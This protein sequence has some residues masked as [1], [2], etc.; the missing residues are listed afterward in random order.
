[1]K[2][3]QQ[4]PL[5]KLRDALTSH[6]SSPAPLSISGLLLAW[7]DVHRRKLPWR[8]DNADAY[9]VWLSEIMLQQTTVKAVIPF[10]EK[11]IALWP[12]VRA[13]ACAPTAEVMSAWAGLGYYSRARN[14]HAC[15]KLVADTYQGSF[16]A[17]E[18]DLRK[19][20]GIGPYTA[21]AISA[22]A[23]DRRAVVVD[24][25][26]ER[27]VSRLFAVQTPLPAAKPQIYTLTDSITPERRCGDFAQSMMDL[28]ASLCAPRAPQCLIC[29]LRALCLAHRS[30]DP[31]TFPRK[32]PKPE[33]PLRRG[34]VFHITRADGA[35]LARTRPG[36]GLLG[37]MTELPTTAWN[38]DFQ[39][40]TAG[41]FAPLI[42]PYKAASSVHHVFTHFALEL[43]VF[44]A[45]VDTETSAPPPYRWVPRE[46]MENEAWPSVMRKVLK[47]GAA[48]ER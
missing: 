27:V 12:D 33:R 24:G 38:V 30:G 18:A 45:T 19:L 32:S 23:F 5:Q 6:R 10:F 47:S 11:F 9:S 36:K 16:P 17:D 4:V 1:M 15:A 39:S 13:L 37:G 41:D 25:N 35:L 2:P 29:P 26:V 7:Y 44:T 14:L 46:K 34:A 40:P 28:G 48:Y 20:P 3:L 21:A 42:A 31:Q 43:L 22:I 8:R